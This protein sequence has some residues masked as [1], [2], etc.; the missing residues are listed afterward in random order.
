MKENFNMVC[1][2][3]KKGVVA[4]ALGAGALFLV[5]GIHAPSYIKTAFQRVRQTAKDSVPAEFDI[6]RARNEI[7][8][9]QPMFDQNKETLARAEVEAEHL[10]REVGAIQANLEKAKTTIVALKDQLKRGEFRLTG[11]HRANTADDIKAELAH[12]LDHYDYTADLL[13]QKQATLKAKQKIIEAARQQLLT[14]REQKQ[15]LTAKLNN[16]EAQ[17]KLL[18]ANQSKNDFNFDG[19]ALARAKQTVTELEERLAVMARKAEI[20]GRYGDLDVPATYVD[21]QRD[22]IKE[23]DQKF[24]DCT[25][26][27][28][29]GDKSL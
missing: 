12:R 23:V 21:P 7:A 4:A 29:G 5:F 8:S 27:A 6:E 24:G 18:E 14:L 20:D 28:K 22:V 3:V 16:I 9:L 17:L 19:S 11:G 2:M 1:S 13:T 25:S 10:E 26:S 15:N